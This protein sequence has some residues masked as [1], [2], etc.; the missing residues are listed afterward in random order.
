[1][2]SAAS[3]WPPR[4]S[5]VA[6][7]IMTISKINRSHPPV[8]IARQA[9]PRSP[10][11][12]SPGD[13]RPAQRRPQAPSSRARAGTRAARSAGPSYTAGGAPATCTPAPAWP[14]RRGAV[15]GR[16]AL[17][18]LR[19]RAAPPITSGARTATAA[20]NDDGDDDDDDS[21]RL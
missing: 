8:G 13:V 18:T 19:A 21:V 4:P 7:Q 2:E 1:M 14:R 20:A 6:W 12:G 5:D 11:K 10:S 9:I 15:E 3:S 17:R 16:R